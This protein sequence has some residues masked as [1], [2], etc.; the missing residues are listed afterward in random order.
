MWARSRYVCPNGPDSQ[1]G[2][3]SI[4]KSQVLNSIICESL[5]VNLIRSNTDCACVKACSTTSATCVQ[6]DIYS[7]G[8]QRILPQKL[9]PKTDMVQNAA[10][11]GDSPGR[12]LIS[13]SV[14]RLIFAHPVR[15]APPS[16]VRMHAIK[17]NYKCPIPAEWIKVEYSANHVPKG[18]KSRSTSPDSPAGGPRFPRGA[19]CL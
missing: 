19:R 4:A 17:V 18:C 3:G 15:R 2:T 1:N 13:P 14:H 8:L 9:G 12:T 10:K 7:A 6:V 16:R 5:S 11:S